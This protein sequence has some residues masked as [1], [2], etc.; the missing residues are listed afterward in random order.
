MAVRRW[1]REELIVAFNLYC[2]TPFGL[3]HTRNR[4]IVDLAEVL[5]R[6]PSAVAWKLANFARLDPALQQRGIS[7][8]SHGSKGEIEI[9]EEFNNDWENL[10]FESEKLLAEKSGYELDERT[11]IGDVESSAHGRDRERLIK[12]RVNQQ[13]FRKAVLATYEY[14]CCITGLPLVE[15]LT[16]SHIVPWAVDAPNRLNPRNGLCLNAIHDRAF[17]RGLLTITPDYKVKISRAAKSLADNVATVDFL[18]R[19]EGT[20]IELPPKFVPDR[21]FL[22]YHNTEIF[23]KG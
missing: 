13:F 20:F 16:A 3:I 22:E 19:Y 2:K 14:R 1:R 21:T 9:W 7:G 8:A 11:G 6:S 23:Q 5:G 18:L 12:S 4:D 15:L 17:D 10:A